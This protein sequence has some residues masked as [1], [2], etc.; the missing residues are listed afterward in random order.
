MPDN[1]LPAP[2]VD[3]AALIPTQRVAEP[4]PES[5]SPARAAVSP[6]RSP[7]RLAFLWTLVGA[8][9]GAAVV[10]GAFLV[11]LTLLP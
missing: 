6:E 7:E 8:V 1:A 2:T 3:L 9:T 4:E 11:L 5:V 10:A